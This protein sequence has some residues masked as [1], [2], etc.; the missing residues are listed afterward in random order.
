MRSRKRLMGAVPILR[1]FAS[2][3]TACLILFLCG[4][5]AHCERLG[6]TRTDASAWSLSGSGSSTEGRDSEALMQTADS[7]KSDLGFVGMM[8]RCHD[9]MLETVFVILEPL[10]PR[11][12]VAIDLETDAF[13]ESTSASLIP[14]GAGVLAPIDIKALID[15]PWY[16]E[17]DLTVR[18]H[19]GPQ[20]QIVAGTVH[21]AGLREA[22]AL[23]LARCGATPAF[24]SEAHEPHQ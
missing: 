10:P 21:L 8:I 14:T 1:L 24:Q 6:L 7:A 17:P 11:T 9:R 15:G 20:A 19:E 18:I 16:G 4:L 2:R 3:P 13:K 12:P 5:P 23:Y 22:L